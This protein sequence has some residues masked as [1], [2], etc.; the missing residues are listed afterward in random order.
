MPDCRFCGSYFPNWAL[1]EGVRRNLASRKYCL[2]CSP[3]GLHNV[4]RLE[5]VPRDPL[6]RKYCP[7]CHQEKP[8]AEFY[9]RKEGR[10]S[11]AW[12]KVCNNE[13]RKARFREDRLAALVHY[14]RGDLK[15]V[16]CGERNI[17]FLALDH[18][19]DD[20]AAHRREVGG[21]GR[22]FFTW[23]RKTGYTYEALV[24]A[25]HN[26][27]MARAMYGQCPHAR[28]GPGAGLDLASAS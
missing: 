7:Q 17:E 27:N 2:T 6:E 3:W 24:V 8:I 19:N 10:W 4:R 28:S 9:L 20:G 23:L 12:C 11:H 26:C 5:R 25:C 15:C 18:I 13:H 14:G 22:P 1:I 21:G 16:C